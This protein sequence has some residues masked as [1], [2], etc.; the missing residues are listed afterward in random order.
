[1]KFGKVV[2]GVVKAYKTA[3]AI[4]KI[5]AIISLIGGAGTAAF[6]LNG[7]QDVSAK[8]VRFERFSGITVDGFDIELSADVINP[9]RITIP[10]QS[11]DYEVYLQDGGSLLSRGSLRGVKLV[12]GMTHLQTKPHVTWTGGASTLAQL[13]LK[14]KVLADVRISVQILPAI[15]VAQF[16]HT[17]DIKPALEQMQEEILENPVGEAGDQIGDIVNNPPVPGGGLPRLP[18]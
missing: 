1:M 8:N 11:I 16:T 6:Y 13:L 12:P 14:D 9:S 2:N 3:N 5:A 4:V 18:V 17:I 7:I 10:I 15:P